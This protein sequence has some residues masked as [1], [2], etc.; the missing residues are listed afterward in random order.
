MGAP[1]TV[2]IF[3]DP[4][5]GQLPDAPTVDTG[6][7]AEKRN[8]PRIPAAEVP[9]ITGLRMSPHGADATLVNISTSGLLAECGIRLKTGST[10][11]IQF[12]GTFEPATMQGRVARCSVARVTTGGALRY[13]VGLAFSAPISLPVDTAR[14]AAAPAPI[15][16]AAIPTAAAPESP[17]AAASVAGSGDADSSS[18]TDAAPPAAA[19]EPPRPLVRNRW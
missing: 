13:H 17:A 2:A 14:A 3:P 4:R 6:A 9:S 7:D 8:A 10:V 18:A 11:T 1:A 5:H 16:S 19:P 12:E 15:S